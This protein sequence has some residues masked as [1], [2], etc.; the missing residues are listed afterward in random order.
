MARPIPEIMTM[1]DRLLASPS[2]SSTAP[3]WDEG[4]RGVI[5]LLAEWLD[6]LRFR[7]QVQPLPGRADQANLIPV[8]GR[9]SPRRGRRWCPGRPSA[10]GNGGAPPPA[11]RS[12]TAPA[13][14]VIRA[15]GPGAPATLLALRCV[16]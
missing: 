2:V 12:R 7:T 3:E 11:E 15:R 4:N 5:E 13:L 14:P 6:A 8:R 9:R 10:G 1:F 16:E